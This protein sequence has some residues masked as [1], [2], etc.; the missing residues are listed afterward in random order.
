[1]ISQSLPLPEK[2]KAP[3]SDAL[4][5]S[6]DIVESKSGL[7]A[8][9]LLWSRAAKTPMSCKLSVQ[10]DVAEFETTYRTYVMVMLNAAGIDMSM[11]FLRTDRLHVTLAMIN[12]KLT[13]AQ[14]DYLQQQLTSVL[15]QLV[16]SD[17]WQV[18]YCG[19]CCYYY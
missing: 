10:I 15:E 5:W 14:W 16:G 12:A 7:R 17:S 2:W 4:S 8:L 6:S 9:S 1:M 11:P 19:R 13:Y 18:Y 3:A